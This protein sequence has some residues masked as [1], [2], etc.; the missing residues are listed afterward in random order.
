MPDAGLAFRRWLFL[1]LTLSS[2]TAAV[3]KL[4]SVLL[5]GG[6]SAG[7]GCFLF[8]FAIL[9]GWISIAFW[10]ALFGV[11]ARLEGVALLPLKE[12]PRGDNPSRTAVLMPVYNE[13]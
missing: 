9:F 12:G 4:W 13:D 7:E 2:T 6:L 8:L 3:V 10:V 1:F 5:S 11:V